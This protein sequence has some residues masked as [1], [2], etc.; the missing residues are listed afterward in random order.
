MNKKNLFLL[1][2]FLLLVLT[3]STVFLFYRIKQKSP[4]YE[5]K[6]LVDIGANQIK[7][8]PGDP[9]TKSIGINKERIV[10]YIQGNFA[11][12]PEMQ[13]PLMSGKVGIKGDP[14]KREIDVLIGAMDGNLT[15][16]LYDESFQGSVTWTATSTKII[17]KLMEPN[18]PVLIKIDLE[19]TENAD[20]KKYVKERESVL[21]TLIGEFQ[22]N[23]FAYE[24]PIDFILITPA[25][26]VI[27]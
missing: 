8:L 18:T 6:S 16:G 20:I 5:D 10:Y 21:D 12:K 25:L 7:A 2:S 11:A 17:Q 27:K 24:L 14:L 13:E 15:Y 19:I 1:L 3:V 9:I 22:S 4:E 26:A 23:K